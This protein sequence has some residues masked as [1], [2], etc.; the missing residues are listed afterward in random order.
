MTAAET[1]RRL[2]PAPNK[3]EN[4][5]KRWRFSLVKEC[6]GIIAMADGQA[7]ENRALARVVG[8]DPRALRQT[9]ALFPQIR[10]MIDPDGK[11]GLWYGLNPNAPKFEIPGNVPPPTNP[12]CIDGK[13]TEPVCLVHE[14]G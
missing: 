1:S 4:A 7:V 5:E 13:A 14:E 9:L 8:Q 12:I 11:R 6:L 3:K 2:Y 10:I